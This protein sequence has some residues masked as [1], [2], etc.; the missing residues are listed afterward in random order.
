MT[1]VS[2]TVPCTPPFYP[3]VGWNVYRDVPIEYPRGTGAR[4][5]DLAHCKSYEST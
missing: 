3:L 1:S 5:P 2:V 4:S